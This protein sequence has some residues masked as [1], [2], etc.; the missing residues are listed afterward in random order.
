[1]RVFAILVAAA[2]T[3][4]ALVSSRRAAGQAKK[5]AKFE[6]RLHAV[7]HATRQK[8]GQIVVPKIPKVKRS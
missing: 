3:V 8:P 4:F 7:E 2:A 5:H 1:M 6:K